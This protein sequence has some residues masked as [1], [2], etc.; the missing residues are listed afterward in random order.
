MEGRIGTFSTTFFVIT[1]DINSLVDSGK[2]SSNAD[3]NGHT[4]EKSITLG[5]CVLF[6]DHGVG[7]R[8]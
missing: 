3:T 8:R 1:S 6:K 5:M 4:E 2:M 7:R